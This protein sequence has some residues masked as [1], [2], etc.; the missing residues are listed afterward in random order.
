MIIVHILLHLATGHLVNQQQSFLPV[1]L[2]LG[3]RPLRL[4]VQDSLE[5]L[6]TS[7]V[8]LD[9]LRPIHIVIPAIIAI[10]VSILVVSAARHATSN[11]LDFFR[12]LIDH[13][14]N[15]SLIVN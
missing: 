11:R 7:F 10:Q 8:V 6:L 14:F 13:V 12:D 9:A 4:K 2:M 15:F 3:L 5:G 1:L